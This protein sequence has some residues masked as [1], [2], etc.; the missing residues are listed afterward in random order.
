MCISSNI[1]YFVCE[2]FTQTVAIA[3]RSAK[4]R[5]EAVSACVNHV[6]S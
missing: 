4:V 2:S 6:Y 3:N 5:L 1:A